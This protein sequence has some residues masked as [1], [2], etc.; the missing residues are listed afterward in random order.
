MYLGHSKEED[1]AVLKVVTGK[2]KRHY[3]PVVFC[4]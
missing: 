3:F 2:E 1:F 4:F